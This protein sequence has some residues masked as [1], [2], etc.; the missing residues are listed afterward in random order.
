MENVVIIGAGQ[1]GA[2]V[3]MNLRENGYGGAIT[4]IGEE[5][6]PPYQR[7]PLSKTFA[8]PQDIDSIL[9]RPTSYY[10][11]QRI[12]LFVD[13]TVERID[14]ESRLVFCDDGSR[15]AYDRLV[16][17]TGAVNRT[18]QTFDGYEN[19]MS[20]RTIADSWKLFSSAELRER[21]VVVGGG[22]IGA[23]IAAAFAAIGKQVCLLEAGDR[24][25]GRSVTSE[26]SA[27]I[28]SGLMAAGVDVRLQAR[29][30]DV[31]SV[32]DRVCEI[33]LCEKDVIACD[34]VV[35]GVGA[36]PRT[37]LAAKAGLTVSNGIA[38]DSVMRTSDPA[39]FALGDCAIV[40]DA[41][42]NERRHESVP[43]ALFQ[44]KTVASTLLGTPPPPPFVQWFW[45]DIGEMKLKIVGNALSSDRSIDVPGL[46]GQAHARLFFTNERLVAAETVNATK[47]YAATRKALER[48][49]AIGC[50]DLRAADFDLASILSART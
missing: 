29:I 35:V 42:G 38:V 45:S 17:S 24:L 25:L 36:T 26:T 48:D 50:D 37:E 19:V 12:A 11:L 4:L 31:R 13:K 34:L 20:V 18:L 5:T 33:V 30:E 47:I 27:Y 49:V 15:H 22:F 6:S 43:A 2:A 3:S 40:R 28:R 23:E 46:G 8:H 39:I 21:V 10:D 14:R 32:E 9:L 44:A 7:P 16:L 41:N 1:A